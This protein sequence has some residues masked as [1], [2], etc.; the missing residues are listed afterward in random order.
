MSDLQKGDYV[1]ATK[2]HD[3]DSRDQWCCGF[4]EGMTGHDNQRYDVVDSEGRP[5]RS[6]GFR[7]CEKIHPVIGK[8]LVENSQYISAIKL[9]LWEYIASE[10][11]NT[12]IENYDYEQSSGNN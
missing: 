8:Y 12:S 7:R 1:L 6:N 2:W 5:F 11:H 9:P 4:F 10:M 3:G